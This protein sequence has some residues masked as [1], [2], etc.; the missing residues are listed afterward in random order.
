VIVA[1]S[2]ADSEVVEEGSKSRV[3]LEWLEESIVAMGW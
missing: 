2:R 3:G 1:S